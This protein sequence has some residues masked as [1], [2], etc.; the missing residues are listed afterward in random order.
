[1]SCWAVVPLKARRSGKTR[2]AGL[3]DEAARAALVQSMLET[4]LSALSAAH[5]IDRIAVVSSEPERTPS[6][7]LALPDPGEGL[8][9]AL[10]TAADRLLDHGA[11]SLLVIGNA[12]IAENR[13]VYPVNPERK[14]LRSDWWD[15]APDRPLGDHDGLTD[16][17][18]DEIV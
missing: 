1:M 8:N 15:D 12:D 7:V 5:E 11:S 10:S 3:L 2:L 4:V 13:I 14:A 9:P 18:R 6:G 17:R 16:R